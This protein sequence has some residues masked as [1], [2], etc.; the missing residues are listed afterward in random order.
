MNSSSYTTADVVQLASTIQGAYSAFYRESHSFSSAT[1]ID[2]NLRSAFYFARAAAALSAAHA[3]FAGVQ[4]RLR[5][6]TTQLG[7]ASSLMQAANSNFSDSAHAASIVSVPV[8]GT[9]DIRSTA[10]LAPAVSVGSLG[11]ILGDSSVSPLS[12][13]TVRATQGA[14]GTFPYELSGVSVTIDGKAAQVTAVSP[15][16]V[17]FY[18]PPDVSTGSVDILVTSEDGRVSQGSTSMSPVAPALF[19][20]GGAGSGAAVAINAVTSAQGSFDVVTQPTFGTDK[21]TRVILFATGISNGAS[22][23]NS[24]NDIRVDQGMI[25][26]VSESVSVE[27]HTSDG[28]T[29]TLPVEFAGK[30]NT[31]PGLD[32]VVVILPAELK[33][34]G[35]VDMTVIVGSQR[36]NTATVN[37]K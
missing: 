5:I 3:P 23:T 37:I 26:N 29:L 17:N 28:R 2:G 10:S 8:I 14:D 34:A 13:Q 31:L 7:Q 27:A 30:Q 33:G 35:D 25:T 1:Q 21:R 20:K 32:E 4:N 15:S 16:Q 22:N 19:T 24:T 36:S 18:I 6:A 11:L 9:A 12:T